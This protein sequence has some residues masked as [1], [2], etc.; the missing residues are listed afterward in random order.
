MFKFSKEEKSSIVAKYSQKLVDRICSLIR[1]DSYTIAEICLICRYKQGYLLYLDENKSDFP[2]YKKR[3][4]HGC[5]SLLPSPEVFIKERFK[6][7]RW[8]SRRSRMSIVV[9]LW[10]MRMEKKQKPKIKEKTIVKKHPAGC[11]CYYFHLDK[12]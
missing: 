10:L 9:N 12:W 6:V 4:T 11:R 7:V 5:N 3:K 1:E 2:T 8:K